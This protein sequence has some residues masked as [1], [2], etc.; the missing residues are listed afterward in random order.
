MKTF[1]A[2][3]FALS[4]LGCALLACNSPILNHSNADDGFR[5]P[6]TNGDAS[7][8]LEFPKHG[9]C[10]SW[11][12][13]KMPTDQDLGGAQ[14]RFWKKALGTENGPF[15]DPNDEVF[16]KLWMPDMGHGSSPVKTEKTL[17]SGGGVIPGVYEATKIFFV[18]PGHWEIWVQLKN[19][20]DLREQAKLDVAI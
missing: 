17:D 15:V 4:L 10:A 7:C 3:S 12:W 14:L 16:V 8:P 18:M 11:T 13:E 19:G 1:R 6:Q 5:A 2:R 9:L 20:A